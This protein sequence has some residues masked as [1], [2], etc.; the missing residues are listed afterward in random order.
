MKTTFTIL[1]AALAVL[2]MTSGGYADEYR[3][4]WVNAWASGFESPSATTSMVNYARSCNVNVVVPEIR[5]RADAYYASS[6]E[7]PGTAIPPDPG[8][9]SLADI[10]SKAHAVGME[11]HPWVVTYRVWTTEAGPPHTTPEHIWYMHPDWLMYSDVG[12]TFYGGISNLDPGHP[13]VEAYLMYVFM[14]IVQ[15]YDI[16]GFALDYIR[17]PGVAWGYNPIAVGRFNAEYGRTGNPSNSDALWQDWRRDQI[18]NLVKRLYLEIKAVKPWVKLGAAVWSTAG[19]ANNSYLQNWDQ[20]MQNH[21]IDY[22]S[23][24]VYTSNNSTLHGWLLDAIGRQYGHHIYPLIDA[25]NNIS[26]NVLPQIDDMRTVG[27]PGVGLYCYSSIPNRTALK[28]ALIGGPFSAFVSP[29]DM[30]WLSAPTKGYL[31]G[32]VRDAS[33]NAIYPATVTILGPGLSTKDTGRGFYGFTEVTPDTYTVRAEAL[34][35]DTSEAPVTIIAGQVADL[36]FT[37]Q[38]ETVPPVISNVRAENIQATNVQIMWDTDEPATSQVDYGLTAAYGTTTPEDMA[39]VQS[40]VVQLIGLTPVTTYHFGVRSYDAARNM[41]ESTDY[42]FTTGDYDN[43]VEIIID[44]QDPGCT[45][46]NT[47]WTGTSAV[48]KWGDDYFWTTTYASNRNASFRP[49]I[50]TAGPYDVYVWYSAG[51]NRTT[52]ARW[53]TVYSGSYVEVRVNE[54]ENGGQWVK[55]ADAVP[56]AVGTSGVVWTFSATGDAESMVIV[57]D[58]A[59]FV[60]VGDTEPP[61]APTNLTAMA[62][63]ASQVSLSWTGSTDNRGVAGYKIYR[64]D[65]E[66]G[67]SVS[68]SY[69]DSGLSA[70]T[71][72]S[73]YVKA[74]DAMNNLSDPSNTVMRYTLSA[75][76]G[77]G[78]VTCDKPAGTWQSNPSFTFTAVGGFGPSTLEYYRYAWDQNGSYAWSGFEPQW[79]SGDLIQTA[80]ADGSWYLHVKGYNAEDLENGSYTYGPFEYDSSGP[81]M[82]TVTDDGEYTDAAGQLYATWSASDPESGIAEYQYAVGTTPENI[83]S[84]QGWTSVGTNTSVTTSGLTLTS[85]TTYYFGVKAR[86]GADAWSDPAVSDGITAADVLGTIAEAKN[87]PDGEAV[88]LSGKI[89]SA[90]FGDHFYICEADRSSGIRVNETSPNEGDSADVSGV[91]QTISGERV[92]TSPSVNSSAGGTVP[93]P[94]SMTNRALGGASLNPYTPGV[95]GGSGVNNIG[96]LVTIVGRVTHSEVGFC[97]IDDGSALQDGSGYI[98]VKVDTSTLSA[99]PAEDAY[100]TITGISA[101]ELSGPNTIRLLKPRRDAD[102]VTY[103]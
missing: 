5:V 28:D 42:T 15:R 94:I 1:L 55:I 95:T 38:L 17:Y 88:M 90:N 31:K 21:W 80:T 16:D 63:S 23:P 26:G 76:P 18:S 14:D 8:Y 85:G 12:G 58:A 59:R 82:G 49:D 69:V 100:V 30:P 97:Y 87:H 74:Y 53:R 11:V 2:T 67:T 47:W 65:L 92:I 75:A 52:Q 41:T 24:M 48:D 51:W 96:L 9:D 7:P 46:Y 91:L 43:P 35:Y 86:N 70:N 72:Y 98:G 36:D 6:I 33:D 89:V 40:H 83:G 68:N 3:A 71:Q 22:V 93:D 79:T 57:A 25:S 81:V 102:V 32:F 64:N 13:T 34:G 20:W 66:V 39:L 19:V 44:N 29:S 62:I 60:Y 61:T 73:Y 27:F 103:P 54:Q 99:S 37:L 77:S 56:F 45:T 10:I 84:I 50:L 101:T 4:L 78:S